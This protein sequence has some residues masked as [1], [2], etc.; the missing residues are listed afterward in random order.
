MTPFDYPPFPH[1][2]QH[3]P[4]GYLATASFRP[5]LRDEF[6]FRCVYCLRRE[7]WEPGASGFEIEHVLPVGR[8]PE[9]AL[10]Y[11]N[12]VYACSICN[13]AKRDLAIAD[14]I[15][16][17]TSKDLMVERDGRLTPLTN[18]ASILVQQM[19]LNDPNYVTWRSWMIR[20]VELAARFDPELHRNLLAYPDDLPDLASLRPPGGNALPEGTA[21]S[22]FA[23]RSRGELPERY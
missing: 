3:A 6:S 13:L 23:R 15:R 21:Q 18:A 10:A 11:S 22:H 7:R 1:R 14:P 19:D 9:L 20:I 8:H 16:V 12:L 4:M 17:F 2:R 5:W